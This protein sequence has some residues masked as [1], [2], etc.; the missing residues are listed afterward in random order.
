MFGSM[1]ISDEILVKS[2]NV[3]L[4]LPSTS[5]HLFLF[6]IFSGKENCSVKHFYIQIDL[7]FL[8]L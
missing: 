7:V 1:L 4:L 6:A 3:C 8:F 5:Y 2:G